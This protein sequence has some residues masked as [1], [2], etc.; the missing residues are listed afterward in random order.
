MTRLWSDGD[1]VQV[2]GKDNEAPEKLKWCGQLHPVAEVTRRWRVR[3]DWW[4]TPIW[5]DYFKLTTETGLLLIIYHD[6]LG[7]QWYVQRLYD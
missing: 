3:T 7:G 5:R 1:P 6:L 2:W 4:H